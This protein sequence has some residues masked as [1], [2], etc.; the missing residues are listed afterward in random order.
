LIQQKQLVLHDWRR[1]YR[2]PFVDY[3]DSESE[4]DESDCESVYSVCDDGD[5]DSGY[6]D[7]ENDSD[8]DKDD[9]GDD[10]NNHRDG[11]GG[12]DSGFD[13]NSSGGFGFDYDT[14]FDDD[15][16]DEEDSTEEDEWSCLES[17]LE[18]WSF[19]DKPGTEP[20]DISPELKAFY[21]YIDLLPADCQFLRSHPPKDLKQFLNKSRPQ[22]TWKDTMTT[23]GEYCRLTHDSNCFSGIVRAIYPNFWTFILAHVS[24]SRPTSGNN[25]KSDGSGASSN[26]PS[27]KRKRRCRED[28]ETLPDMDQ[29]YDGHDRKRNRAS[30]VLKRKCSDADLLEMGME[31]N[32]DQYDG[33]AR[34]RHRT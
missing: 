20:E 4:T 26:S 27:L 3:S 13:D 22:R 34:K 8:H 33:Q 16:S 11:D 15:S 2:N 18:D 28:W 6:G 24:P 7:N 21:A 1:A 19:K 9:S 10:D 25:H 29:Y 30:P 23:Y 14:D 5:D 12:H 17:R 32:P 31:D